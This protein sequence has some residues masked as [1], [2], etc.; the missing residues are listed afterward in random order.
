[1]DKCAAWNDSYAGILLI[2]LQSTRT[3]GLRARV[4]LVFRVWIALNC[5]E[6]KGCL[7]ESNRYGGGRGDAA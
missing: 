1:M 5:R 6:V 2:Y 3:I 7:G 4:T